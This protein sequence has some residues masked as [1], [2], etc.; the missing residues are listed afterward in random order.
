MSDGLCACR[1]MRA[2][3]GVWPFLRWSS[4]NW[5]ASVCTRMGEEDAE[6]LPCVC[7]PPPRLPRRTLTSLFQFQEAAAANAGLPQNTCQ[8]RQAALRA[9]NPRVHNDKHVTLRLHEVARYDDVA[10]ITSLM[11]I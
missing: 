8:S 9:G 3:E 11:Q 10:C 2:G 4:T 6:G 1:F 5:I 7:I